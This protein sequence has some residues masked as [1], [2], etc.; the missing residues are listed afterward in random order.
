[1]KFNCK[2]TLAF[3]IGLMLQSGLAWAQG[4]PP[5][6]TDDPDTPGDGHWEINLAAI[7]S[8]S[9]KQHITNLPDADMNYGWGDKLQLK[10]DVPVVVGTATDA[11]SHTALGAA[12]FGI[13]WRF[14]EEE[15]AGI[16]ISTYPQYLTNLNAQAV[17]WGLADSGHQIFLPIEASGH[18]GEW[19]WVAEVGRNLVAGSNDRSNTDAWQTGQLLAHECGQEIE[20]MAELYETHNPLGT[21]V[22]LNLGMRWKLDE[23]STLIASSGHE[24]ADSGLTA[25]SAL[26]YL[27]VQLT[28]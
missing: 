2:S 8:H 12:N 7:H 20:C 13:K 24:K 3:L 17:H 14:V 11:G 4:G 1:M 25:R 21:K 26:I 6:L 19:A 28:Y 18:W 23:H 5:M 22:L 15:D 16:A 10:M 27:G 9:G